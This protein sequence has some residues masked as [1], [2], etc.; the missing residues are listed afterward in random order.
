MGAN[1][2]KTIVT[3]GKRKK[4]PRRIENEKQIVKK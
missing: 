2:K 1:K 4:I 3:K